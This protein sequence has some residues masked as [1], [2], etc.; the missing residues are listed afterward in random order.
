MA[1]RPT[2]GKSL[3]GRATQ[4]VIRFLFQADG[5]FGLPLMRP[6]LLGGSQELDTFPDWCRGNQGIN[7]FPSTLTPTPTSHLHHSSRLFKGV[8]EI[9]HL[10]W[11]HVACKKGR[12]PVGGHPREEAEQ[13][14]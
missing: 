4:T 1:S 9:E 14:E 5:S 10:R 8:L 6:E 7:T 3:E 13:S 2:G 12:G 11:H